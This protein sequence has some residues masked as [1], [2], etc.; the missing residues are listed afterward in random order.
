MAAHAEY[1]ST[2]RVTR[3]RIFCGSIRAPTLDIALWSRYVSHSH[4]LWRRWRH[5]ARRIKWGS[6]Q[7][8]CQE[9][10]RSARAAVAHGVDAPTQVRQGAGVRA[11]SS[12]HTTGAKKWWKKG[13]GQRNLRTTSKFWNLELPPVMRTFAYKASLTS[14]MHA[15]TAWTTHSATPACAMPY[16]SANDRIKW[17]CNTRCDKGLGKG[18]VG[19]SNII[20][21]SM[22]MS[23]GEKRSS[24]IATLSLDTTITCG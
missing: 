14:G 13:P 4:R 22:P 24:G 15:S 19:G 1:L 5:R 6:R 12:A 17:H 3:L 18:M 23:D 21:C 11:I 9:Y 8:R 2:T 16:K 10:I 20:T 7:M